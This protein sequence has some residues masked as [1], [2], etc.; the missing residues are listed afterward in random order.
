[1]HPFQAKPVVGFD[2][3]MITLRTVEKLE[4]AIAPLR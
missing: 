3:T 4:L 1:M 2:L